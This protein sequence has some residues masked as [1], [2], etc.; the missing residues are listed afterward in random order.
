MASSNLY[1][2]LFKNSVSNLEKNVVKKIK[3]NNTIKS[4][5]A[6]PHHRVISLPNI[7][8][9][10]FAFKYGSR[11]FGRDEKMSSPTEKNSP[12]FGVHTMERVQDLLPTEAVFKMHSSSDVTILTP[13]YSLSSDMTL[14]FKSTQQHLTAEKGRLVIPLKRDNDMLLEFVVCA[15]LDDD[16]NV[17]NWV[18]DF[19]AEDLCIFTPP[20]LFVERKGVGIISL[21]MKDNDWTFVP[22]DQDIC[23]S[24]FLKVRSTY[25]KVLGCGRDMYNPNFDAVRF[26]TD[27]RKAANN[28]KYSIVKPPVFKGNI[29]WLHESALSLYR[30]V[31]FQLT[32]IDSDDYGQLNIRFQNACFNRIGFLVHD[33]AI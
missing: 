8:R 28:A 15:G 25:Y 13:W 32:K 16:D 12:M 6:N 10:A 24:D 4:D 17:P 31:D 22:K 1:E 29:I 3:D 5:L 14:L 26:T 23:E 2:R 27:F 18:N 20:S 30:T 7:P 19:S 11:F 9:H 21:N 33:T